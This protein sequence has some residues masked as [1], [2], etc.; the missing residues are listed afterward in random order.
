MLGTN[1]YPSEAMPYN[2]LQGLSLL[3]E[4]QIWQ[5][6][7]NLPSPAVQELLINHFFDEVASKYTMIEK[8]YF[9]DHYLQWLNACR[10]SKPV[11]H[12]FS[13][14]LQ[15]YPALLMQLLALS[16]QYVTED[17]SL[18]QRLQLASFSQCASLSSA[19]SMSSADFMHLID[20]QRPSILGVQQN[21]LKACWLKNLGRG[22]ESWQA[23][24]D[25]LR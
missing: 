16:L 22:L 3:K 15:H 25:A 12:T 11:F 4:A 13:V 2:D 1:P 7:D 18:W 5:L 6:I 21:L 20:R 24:G 10:E 23:T 14:D 9:Q 19:Y 8:C 17:H